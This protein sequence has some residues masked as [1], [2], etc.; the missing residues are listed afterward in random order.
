MQ[1]NSWFQRKIPVQSGQRRGRASWKEWTAGQRSPPS[2]RT[3]YAGSSD[4]TRRRDAFTGWQQVLVGVGTP[5]SSG[6]WRLV[7]RKDVGNGTCSRVGPM[8]RLVSSRSPAWMAAAG[9]CSCGRGW[10]SRVPWSSRRVATKCTSTESP[11][12]PYAASRCTNPSC[13]Q[14]WP[15]AYIRPR[16]ET[17]LLDGKKRRTLA[18][19]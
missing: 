18:G 16:D 4:S 8:R 17:P 13:K 11:R 1:P 10:R 15:G 3:P 12:T 19:N 5:A 14:S 7:R 2:P 6:F 9:A